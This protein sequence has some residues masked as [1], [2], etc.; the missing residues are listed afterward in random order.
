M[1]AACIAGAIGGGLVGT[2]NAGAVSF[3][4]PSVISLIVYLGDGFLTY[5]IAL[6]AA[7]I[8]GFLL[9]YIFGIVEDDTDL[10]AD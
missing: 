5:V 7:F 6:V 10:Q 8:I 2:S 3:A 1:I 9:T 4:F